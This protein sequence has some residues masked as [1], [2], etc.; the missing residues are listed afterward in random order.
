LAL[1]L[2]PGTTPNTNLDEDDDKW[3]GVDFSG[4]DDLRSLRGFLDACDYL[5]NDASSNDD[6]G[7]EL[8]WP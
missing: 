4:L 2:T 6:N 8:T 1:C 5:L 7:Y 3:P